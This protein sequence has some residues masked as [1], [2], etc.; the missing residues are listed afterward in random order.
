MNRILKL[1]PNLDQILS[2]ML[3]M[4]FL[5]IHAKIGFRVL[6]QSVRGG[7]DTAKRVNEDG[8]LADGLNSPVRPG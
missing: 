8:R 1:K 6:I 5:I 4:Q 7:R 2:R 3:Q